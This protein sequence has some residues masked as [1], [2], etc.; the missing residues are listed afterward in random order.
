[1]EKDGE[2][3]DGIVFSSM[4]DKYLK[5]RHYKLKPKKY[6]TNDFLFELV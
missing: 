5:T 1:M 4:N 2:I 3:I 6:M